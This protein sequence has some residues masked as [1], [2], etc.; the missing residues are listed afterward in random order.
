ML[1]EHA[2]SSASFP[3]E[4]LLGVITLERVSGAFGNSGEF[5]SRMLAIESFFRERMKEF[6]R[7]LNTIHCRVICIVRQLLTAGLFKGSGHFD[8]LWEY[9]LFCGIDAM[10]WIQNL[11][12][13]KSVSV[14]HV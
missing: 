13:G 4:P 14:C 5:A 9:K 12:E 11:L 3:R 2:H 6:I 10:D 7:R 8:L 1:V